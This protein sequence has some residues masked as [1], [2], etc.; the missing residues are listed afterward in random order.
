[1]NILQIAFSQIM[2]L[3]SLTTACGVLLHDTHIDK[4]V[5]TSIK[6][7]QAQVNDFHPSEMAGRLRSGG[8]VHPHAEHLRVSKDG[9]ASQAAIPRRRGKRD[10]IKKQIKTGFHADNF[11]MPLAGEWA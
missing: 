8:N 2:T 9:D 1:M 5:T 6:V 11:C 3:L 7:S 4:A 10:I